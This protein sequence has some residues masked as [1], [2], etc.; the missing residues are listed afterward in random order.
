MPPIRLSTVDCSHCGRLHRPPEVGSRTLQ[1]SRHADRRANRLS[2]WSFL[3]WHRRDRCRINRHVVDVDTGVREDVTTSEGTAVA[4]CTVERLMRRLGLRATYICAPTWAQVFCASWGNLAAMAAVRSSRVPPKL[5]VV[6][7]VR[8]P[9]PPPLGV[10]DPATFVG[11]R[12][13]SLCA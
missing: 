9:P 10:P 2:P 4:R 13:V 1:A 5:P 8:P 6:A 11:L 7:E 3:L 12:I